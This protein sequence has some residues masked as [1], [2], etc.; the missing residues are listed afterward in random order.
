M[1]LN[2][3]KMGLKTKIINLLNPKFEWIINK[4]KKKKNNIKKKILF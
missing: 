2:E 4:K 1:I 3:D